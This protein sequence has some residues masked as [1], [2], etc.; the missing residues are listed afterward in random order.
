MATDDR[1]EILSVSLLDDNRELVDEL[2]Q[3][4]AQ[5]R[6]EFGWHYLLD[7]VWVIKNLELDNLAKALD[8][9]AGQGVLQWYLASKGI[10]VLS[11]DRGSRDFLPLH[12]RKFYPTAGLRASD[13]ASP[14]KTLFRLGSREGNF[15]QKLRGFARDLVYW[16]QGKSHQ[17][18]SGKVIFYHQDL[19]TLKN[20]ANNTVDAV[21]A[22][23]SLEHNQ[24]D[25]L[26]V[27]VAE[28]IRVLKPGGKLV[29]TLS[30]TGDTDFYHEPS[31]GWTYSEASMRAHF[32]L[33]EDTVSNYDQYP[34]LFEELKNSSELK[35]GLAKFYFQRGEGGMPWG[36]WN[37]QYVPIGVCKVKPIGD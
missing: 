28:L 11:V 12:Y 37:P 14:A 24:P 1:L 19:R 6:L 30:T 18:G 16:L 25:Q 8:A 21:V 20:I 23:S 36:V 33:D 7:L 29:A 15:N 4:A 17:A 27:V 10:D 32:G 35:E 22:V 5:V 34:V 9:G 2:K 31:S 13:L 3:I 26:P